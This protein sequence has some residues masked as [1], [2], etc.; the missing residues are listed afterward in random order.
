MGAENLTGDNIDGPKAPTGQVQVDI[1]FA[2][3]A[4]SQL[5]T[6]QISRITLRL[7][8]TSPAGTVVETWEK[9][10]LAIDTEQ[11]ITA[12]YTAAEMDSRQFSG[13]QTYF[14]FFHVDDGKENPVLR[15]AFRIAGG[16]THLSEDMSLEGS[17]GPTGKGIIAQQMRHNEILLKLVTVGTQQTQ[18]TM[19]SLVREL[20][21]RLERVET[22]EVRVM[23]LHETLQDKTFERDMKRENQKSMREVATTLGNQ[24]LPMIG[25]K[26]MGAG[27]G[28]P[29]PPPVTAPPAAP[30][31][32]QQPTPASQEAQVLAF[33]QQ[34]VISFT[35]EQIM[36]MA[37]SMDQT[38]RDGFLQ[39]YKFFKMHQA[40]AAKIAAE[41]QAPEV[42]VKPTTEG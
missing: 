14:A 12:I 9:G 23:E 2:R 13:V 32:P 30:E 24:L 1:N 11:I 28:P 18:N 19:M 17:E 6:K 29:P 31:D 3:W 33:I 4:R 7:Q 40:E 38:Q 37:G 22:R 5:S 35:D 25:A 41:N 8:D 34:L 42:T 10:Q 27:G 39:V 20:T 21:N 16:Q 36:A 15:S 26:L